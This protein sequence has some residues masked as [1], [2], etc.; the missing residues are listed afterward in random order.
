[1]CHCLLL[2]STGICTYKVGNGACPSCGWCQFTAD[3]VDGIAC[4]LQADL[5]A[6]QTKEGLAVHSGDY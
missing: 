2:V 4:P 3:I 6:A 1:M 5:V